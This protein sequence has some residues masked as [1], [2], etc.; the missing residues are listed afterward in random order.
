MIVVVR[1]SFLEGTAM[2]NTVE[3]IPTY[4]AQGLSGNNQKPRKPST[5]L[6]EALQKEVARG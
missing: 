1:A 4:D 5:K 6:A 2:G 3:R